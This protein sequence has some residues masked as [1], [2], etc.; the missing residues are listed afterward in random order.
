[1]MPGFLPTLHAQAQTRSCTIGHSVPAWDVGVSS[2]AVT[3]L[4]AVADGNSGSEGGAAAAPGS[5]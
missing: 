5:D 1:M 4:V 2:I 3:V